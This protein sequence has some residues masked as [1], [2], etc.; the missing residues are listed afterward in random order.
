MS[1]INTVK[2]YD[3]KPLPNDILV[4]EMEKGYTKTK[5]GIYLLNDTDFK[6]SNIKH[7]W[8]KVYKVGKNI[9]YIKENQWLLVQHGKWTTGFVFERNGEK[10]YIQKIN[11][12]GILLVS[13]EKPDLSYEKL[14]KLI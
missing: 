5:S 13:D 7:R 3:I 4:V 2:G 1:A 11:P 10:L 8:C 14:E 9:D 12:E 6:E